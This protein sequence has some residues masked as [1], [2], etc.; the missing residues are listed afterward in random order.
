MRHDDDDHPLLDE[1]CMRLLGTS[2]CS[3]VSSSRHIITREMYEENAPHDESRFTE[4]LIRESAP[5]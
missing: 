3:V 2:R 5:D 4:C 1:F